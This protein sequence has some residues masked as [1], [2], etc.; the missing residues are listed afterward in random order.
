MRRAKGSPDDLTYVSYS[1]SQNTAEVHK[2]GPGYV[3]FPGY[4]DVASNL[5]G[6]TASSG[7]F[8][9]GDFFGRGYDQ[10]IY[11]LYNNSNNRAEIHMFDPSLQKAVG[12]YDVQTDLGGVSASSG[13]FAAGDFLGIGHDQLAYV[14]NSGSGNM[15]EVHL[16]DQS[17]TRAIGIYDVATN[18]AGITASGGTFVGGD[19]MGLG[20]DQLAFVLYSG[21]SGRVEIH[22]L[23]PDLRKAIGYTDIA[24]NVGSV[25]PTH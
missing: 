15:V 16:F 2:F 8:V 20:H 9:T 3:K 19:F 17:L 7:T 6:V 24:T 1:G 14:L 5:G 21:G 11:I 18:M 23:S 13:T 22:M 10:L 25:D 12:Y 4:Y